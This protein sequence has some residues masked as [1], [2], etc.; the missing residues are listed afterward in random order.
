MAV[1]QPRTASPNRG[2]GRPFQKGQSGNPK[3]RPPSVKFLTE[4]LREALQENDGAAIRWIIARLVLQSA[5]GAVDATK[6]IFDRTEGKVAQPIVGDEEAPIP[7]T[8]QL[9]KKGRTKTPK[10]MT[11][12][13]LEAAREQLGGDSDGN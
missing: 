7:V 11:D 1:K 5:E 9:G 12:E 4:Y 2:P 13:E 10:E 8:F 3:G 6:L